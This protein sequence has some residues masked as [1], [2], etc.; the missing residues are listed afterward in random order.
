MQLIPSHLLLS[1]AS[2]APVASFEGIVAAFSKDSQPR[3]CQPATPFRSLKH[4]SMTRIP[5]SSLKSVDLSS[6]W[7]DLGISH[8]FLQV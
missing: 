5:H 4:I 3:G 2:R 6:L 1:D 8:H 7:R